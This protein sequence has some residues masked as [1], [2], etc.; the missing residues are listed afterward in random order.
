MTTIACNFIALNGLSVATKE[1]GGEERIPFFF[2]LFLFFLF[3]SFSFFWGK[4][5]HMRGSPDLGLHVNITLRSKTWPKR[6]QSIVLC[7]GLPVLGPSY[8]TSYKLHSNQHFRRNNLR[9]KMSVFAEIEQKPRKQLR[10]CAET[11]NVHI[12]LNEQANLVKRN[13]SKHTDVSIRQI[14]N[15]SVADTLNKK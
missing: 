13:S 15:H 11:R 1:G 8:E 7:S 5:T 3:L 12:Y 14:W 9:N 6:T 10:N 2:F 4:S